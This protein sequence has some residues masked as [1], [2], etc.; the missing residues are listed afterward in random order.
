M[1]WKQD[2]KGATGN[3][4]HVALHLPD[5]T[6]VSKWPGEGLPK[7]SIRKKRTVFGQYFTM[8]D[9]FYNEGKCPDMLIKIPDDFLNSAKIAVWFNE[10][11]NRIDTKYNLKIKGCSD[12]VE[13]ALKAGDFVVFSEIRRYIMFGFNVPDD[14]AERLLM[15]LTFR[16]GNLLIKFFYTVKSFC[17]WLVFSLFAICCCIFGLQ[18]FSYLFELVKWGLDALKSE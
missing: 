18:F 3:V 11:S 16:R 10:L 17:A 1:I 9:D 6:Y 8:E 4:G 2:V 7:G 5:E 15:T 13:D 12:M 14:F